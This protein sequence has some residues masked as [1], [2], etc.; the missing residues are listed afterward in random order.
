MKHKPHFSYLDLNCE[1]NAS[2]GAPEQMTRKVHNNF[3]T[4][5]PNLDLLSE[6]KDSKFVNYE[7]SVG[8]LFCYSLA[9][10]IVI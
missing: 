8:F 4:S 3:A 10:I 6:V 7:I 1:N 2:E 9:A 5:F